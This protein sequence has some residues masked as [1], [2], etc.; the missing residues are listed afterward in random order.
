MTDVDRRSLRERLRSTIDDAFRPAEAEILARAAVD[1][2]Y[3]RVDR[4]PE[5]LI[6]D[7][8][9]LDEGYTVEEI[10]RILTDLDAESNLF[11]PRDE[12]GPNGLANRVELG[13][14]VGFIDRLER[15][16]LGGRAGRNDGPND[17]DPSAVFDDL[18]AFHDSYLERRVNRRVETIPIASHHRST[19]S[20][21]RDLDVGSYEHA[22]ELCVPAFS[23]ETMPPFVRENIERWIENGLTVNVLLFGEEV[24]SAQESGR[25]KEQIRDGRRKLQS[26]HAR[27]ASSPGELNY[28]FVT[29]SDHT[30]FR[31]LLVRSSDPDECTYRLFVLDDGRERG[32]NST[33]LRGKDETTVYQ[34]LD[35]YFE[36]AW[37]A[38]R[39]PG[40]RGTVKEN[41]S[42]I[43]LGIAVA[44]FA[45][46]TYGWVTQTVPGRV[47][48]PGIAVTVAVM[49]RMFEQ[50]YLNLF[51]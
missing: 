30:H 6:H 49:L 12:D 37:R 21:K 9:R 5:T 35:D 14:D 4:L 28:R 47:A 34:I 42:A 31:G 45:V 11:S 13:D 20:F 1:Y 16:A 23:F 25:V 29:E 32:V 48:E 19:E 41:R 51:F 15:R 10:R 24:G 18:R 33:V 40:W 50:K 38:A 8:D 46:A 3:C 22:D 43:G 36:R 44:T 26:I 2:P 39:P 17:G 27:T 7:L